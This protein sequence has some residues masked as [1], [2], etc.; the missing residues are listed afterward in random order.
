MHE[1]AGGRGG[2]RLK[3]FQNPGLQEAREWKW[4]QGDVGWLLVEA[5]IEL[6][7]GYENYC[8]CIAKT[9]WWITTDYF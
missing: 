1:Q 5:S 4:S 2:V 7:T 8:C 9:S 6:E 3:L